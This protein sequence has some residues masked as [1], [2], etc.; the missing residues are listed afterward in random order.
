MQMYRLT[1]Y[2]LCLSNVVKKNFYIRNNVYNNNLHKT[3]IQHFPRL[4]EFS[5]S[6][7]IYI[8]VFCK[9]IQKY[10]LLC[11]LNIR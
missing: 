9:D 3:S 8:V 2:R 7:Y 5:H 4:N 1:Q 11:K 6:F 10:N